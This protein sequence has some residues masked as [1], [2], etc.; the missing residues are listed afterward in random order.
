MGLF[1]W[2]CTSLVLLVGHN[3]DDDDDIN[4]KATTPSTVRTDN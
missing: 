2:Y 1:A 4:A 3:D